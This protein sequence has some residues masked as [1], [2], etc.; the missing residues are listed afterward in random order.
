MSYFCSFRE[1]FTILHLRRPLI[2]SFNL[3]FIVTPL[4]F[5]SL[6][7]IRL[8]KR[9]IHAITIIGTKHISH[10]YLHL[11]HPLHPYLP[12]HPYD[13]RYRIRLEFREHH[14]F[15]L[16]LITLDVDDAY[17]LVFQG[18]LS[19]SSSILHL[20]HVHL[21]HRHRSFNY[22]IDFIIINK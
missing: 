16:L 20:Q 8:L 17:E 1:F 4:L 22:L 10:P 14:T 19:V 15:I 13:L 7:L 21:P 9:Q 3:H 18:H 5:Y 2:F 11:G 12:F 6:M